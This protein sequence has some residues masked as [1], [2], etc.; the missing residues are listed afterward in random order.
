MTLAL[1]SE[2]SSST[3]AELLLHF[4]ARVE[5]WSD[6]AGV[7]STVA[8]VLRERLR[9][10]VVSVLRCGSTPG[11]L[12]VLAV[13]PHGAG[14][15]PGTRF[16]P[17]HGTLIEAVRSGQPQRTVN[18]YVEPDFIRSLPGDTRS[19]LAVPVVRAGTVLG[20]IHLE[21]ASSGRLMAEADLLTDLFAQPLAVA[22]EIGAARA[23]ED[24]SDQG[25]ARLARQ[26]R[27]LMSLADH[28]ARSENL[29]EALQRVVSIAAELVPS[30][31]TVLMLQHPE[32]KMLEVVA[33]AGTLEFPAG[34]LI[35]LDGTIAGS[36]L[37]Q[38]RPVC[39]A[40]LGGDAERFCAEDAARGIRDALVVPLKSGGKTF[41]AVAILN[42]VSDRSSAEDV[43]LLQ[44]LADQASALEPM[45]Q[46][47]P[48]RQQI[49]DASMI[50]EVGRAMT[51]TLGLD[52]VLMLVVQ[53]AQMLVNGKCAAVG[54]LSETGDSV[55]LASTS[56]TLR[57]SQGTS[58]PLHGSLMGW[59]VTHGE[60][61]ITPG[62]SD[63]P[64]SAPGDLRMGP[65]VIVPL[66]S[67]GQ[68]RGALLVARRE[69]APEATDED[70]DALKKLGAYAAIAIDN[71]RLYEAQTELSRALQAQA[72]ELERA[73]A[74]LRSSQERLV[75]SE[76]MA[77][78]GR[79]TAGIAHEINSPLGSILNCLQLAL[80]YAREY[81]ASAGDP[82]VTVD[83]HLGIAGDL[84]DSL[85]L[86]EG[87]A[88][89]V[90][91]FV[92]T[93]KSQTRMGE[94][95]IIH[96]DPVDEI[97]N[98]IILLQHELRNRSVTVQVESE[99][100]LRITGD[101]A[102]FAVVVQNLLSNAIDALEGAEGA[103]TVRLRSEPERVVLEVED[104]GCGIP[105][106][107]RPRIYDYLFTTKDVGQGTGLGLSM[108]H[109]IVT[110]NF[111][112]DIDFRSEVGM[113]TTFFVTFP[114][115]A[116][117]K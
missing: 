33:S 4:L 75:V 55:R 114:A 44:S 100:D 53:A 27:A 3:P 102:K 35:P 50:A 22:M 89:R 61:V 10:P 23:S 88:R 5:D 117:T 64:R 43:E 69:G 15:I 20:V 116:R 2:S 31:G 103:V 41:G 85:S 8:T 98:T 76:K 17:D 30:E 38:G 108:V 14:M 60:A 110:S 65:G 106:A 26:A 104:H 80:S 115:S 91:Q 71:A 105:E 95:S 97:N 72:A 46:M 37:A 54:L 24:P 36:A 39:A 40:P 28:L 29:P 92:R 51:G 13:A 34:E 70:Q 79:V 1:Q 67:R 52:E 47:G 86:A 16:S 7:A 84:I 73:Y 63:D 96:F 18:A 93:I 94:E 77:A 78:L 45:R 107:I 62:V 58:M 101:P 109:S 21:Y 90:A 66:E 9:Q 87:A 112:G 111:K 6:L 74:D 81:H 83:D 11:S 19:E 32:R 25:V 42:R 48:L 82:E 57:K 12:Q 59:V 49:S 99:R 113:G 56:G 68:I